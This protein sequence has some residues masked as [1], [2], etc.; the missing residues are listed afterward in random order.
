MNHCCNDPRVLPCLIAVL[1]YL[2]LCWVMGEGEREGQGTIVV[3][4]LAM[5]IPLSSEGIL[6]WVGHTIQIQSQSHSLMGYFFITTSLV[7]VTTYHVFL[8]GNW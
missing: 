6:I 8:P 7:L 3:D 5:A 1:T 4:C 2:T